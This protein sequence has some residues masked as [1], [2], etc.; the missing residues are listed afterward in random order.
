MSTHAGRVSGHWPRDVMARDFAASGNGLLGPVVCGNRISPGFRGFTGRRIPLARGATRSRIGVGSSISDELAS[1]TAV[2][3]T[4][5]S[6]EMSRPSGPGPRRRVM[7]SGALALFAFVPCGAQESVASGNPEPGAVFRDCPACPEMVVVPAGTVMLG[8]SE[9]F[10]EEGPRRRVTIGSPFAVGVHEVTFAEWDACA[11]GGGC[12]GYLPSDVG[13][14]R[15]RQPVV[16][17]SWEDA[18]AYLEWLSDETGQEYRLLRVAEWEYVIRE[19]VSAQRYPL[20]RDAARCHVAAEVPPEWRPDYSGCPGRVQI[21]PVG[22][23][24]PNGFGLHDLLGNVWE[25]TEDCGHD[26]Y[27]WVPERDVP[28]SED[29]AE[30]QLRGG[31]AHVAGGLL[32]GLYLAGLSIGSRDWGVGFRVAR[33][34]AD[35]E[36]LDMVT[37]LCLPLQSGMGLRLLR[38]SQSPGNYLLPGPRAPPGTCLCSARS[39]R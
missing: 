15:G 13:W 18:Q 25:W 14:G 35:D 33:P 4:E 29:C 19:G 5:W 36:G 16:N 10:S 12:G 28:T 7:L 38:V 3:L 31:S 39:F 24:E 1:V 2:S 27:R 30:R 37:H 22:S 21:A 9:G 8:S 6:G 34:L 32:R 26:A 20:E 17:V 11:A 23:L